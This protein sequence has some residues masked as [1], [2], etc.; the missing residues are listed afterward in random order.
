MSAVLI[1]GANRGLGLEFVRQYSAVGWTVFACCRQPDGAA[2]LRALASPSVRLVALDVTDHARIEAVGRDLA[3]EPVDVL[4]N[5]AGVYGPN[6]M[7]LGRIDYRAW[8]EVLAINTLAPLKMTE[9]FLENVGRSGRKIIA[10][11]SSQQGSMTRNTEGRHYLYRSSKAALNAVVKSLSIDL[12]SR[13]VIAVSLH[14]GWVQTDMGGPTATLTPP[15][16][17]AGV[18]RV[19]D[20]LRPDD[21]G[22]FLSYDGSEI[23]W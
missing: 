8:A 17:V 2:E 13:G 6:K 5:N 3:G 16:S 23:P 20:G 21:S 9:T 7:F 22:K 11:V 1:T 10:F 18:R 19:L 12:R 15:E 14:P 4:L